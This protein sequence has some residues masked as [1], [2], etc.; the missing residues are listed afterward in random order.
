MLQGFTGCI[1][2]L[3]KDDMLITM[4][5]EPRLKIHYILFIIVFILSISLAYLVQVNQ[6]WRAVFTLPA[7]GVLFSI[8]YKIWREDAS[9]LRD[10]ELQ[11]RQQDFMLGTASH[12]ANV[13]YDKHAIFCEEYMT[14][15]QSGFQ[16]LRRDGASKG[17]MD[18]G[19]KLV[20]VR[21][22]H[23]TWLTS[24]IEA[25]L[26]PFEQALI[27]IG[28]KD[29]LINHLPMGEKRNQVIEEVYN[30][31]GLIMGH[32]PAKNEEELAISLQKI[33]E[34]IREILGVSMYTELRV[35]AVRLAT[36]R[37]T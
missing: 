4:K 35:T 27:S 28:A 37:V 11:N 12:M 1:N 3:S 32:N 5:I 25:K 20:N 14:G 19:R 36:K 10:I 16:E 26:I 31:F 17:A 30:F 33:I 6:T 23:S 24:E 9:H 18:I 13:V 29:G 34:N 2:L 22:K 7:V 15:V 8:L 21:Q